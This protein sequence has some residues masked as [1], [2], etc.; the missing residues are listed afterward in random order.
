MSKSIIESAKK[1]W[2]EDKDK[3]AIELLSTVDLET[4]GNANKLI[5]EIYLNATKG[6]SNIK[7]SIRS[8]RKYLEKA[9]QLGIAEAG[10]ELADLYYLGEGV[11]QNYSNAV[12][13]WKLASDL[14]CE[15]SAFKLA[16]FY[17]DHEPDNIEEAIKLYKQL[18]SSGEF[19]GNSSYKLSR[20]YGTAQYGMQKP[21]LKLEYLHEG[22]KAG[23]IHCCMELALKYYR[24]DGIVKDRVKAIALTEKACEND[25]FKKEA[26]VVRDKMKQGIEL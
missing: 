11:K 16:N 17:Y 6:S 2:R 23:H 1:L 26:E 14:G 15:L 22:A 18:I 24:G 10:L 20:I 9:L 5:G 21:E 3:E 7:R 19:I 25:L 12:K 4:N 13:Y 8:G